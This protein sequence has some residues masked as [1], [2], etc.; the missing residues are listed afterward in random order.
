MMYG[1]NF[2]TPE[3]IMKKSPCVFYDRET[4]SS[5][6]ESLP[7]EDHLRDFSHS[8]LPYVLVPGP[9]VAK[10][11]LGVKMSYQDL[12]PDFAFWYEEE[13]FAMSDRVLPGWY[14]IK[15]E[16]VRKKRRPSLAAPKAG[17]DKGVFPN[18]AEAVWLALTYHRVYGEN[19][20]PRTQVRTATETN[21]ERPVSF[22]FTES[23]GVFVH[24]LWGMLD[25]K[26][27]VRARICR[28]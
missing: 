7:T 17:C 23:H 16:S 27:L 8:R 1:R 10:T 11:L 26:N 14:L 13:R 2:V 25:R 9:P 24:I 12:F 15:K 5:L 6:Q 3:Q 18:I 20:F 19:L 21:E 4:L 28:L 22:V